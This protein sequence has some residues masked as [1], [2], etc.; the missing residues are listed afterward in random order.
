MNLSELRTMI[1][2]SLQDDGVYRDST[3]VN[4]A[5]NDGYFMACLFS[6][7]DERKLD[8]YAD[9]SRNFAYVP[10]TGNVYCIAPLAVIDA[11]TGYRLS[12]ARVDQFN[13]YSTEW[14][15]LVDTGALYYAL[16]D[17]H[18]N[19]RTALVTVPINQNGHA[20]YTVYGA[21]IPEQLSADTDVPRF[22]AG[23]H[24]LLYHYAR[25][26]LLVGEP[27]FGDKAT[28]EYGL[29]V[30]RL[31]ELI[32]SIKARFPSGRDYEPWP[33]EFAYSGITTQEQVAPVQEQRNEG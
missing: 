14:E 5:I 19:A 13:F 6:M 25:F 29:F 27:G 3:Q 22:E 30:N 26:Y 18:D 1:K 15:S 9:G 4:I 24:D 20:Y 8:V 31:S 10:Y 16:L 17:P 12:P 21:C 23:F 11:V 32:T 7:C 33:I 28:A 2:D